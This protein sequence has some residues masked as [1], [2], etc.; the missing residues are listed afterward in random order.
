MNAGMI[1]GTPEG[2]S[3]PPRERPG[4]GGAVDDG[5]R[6]PVFR[7]VVEVMGL[8]A[9]SEWDGAVRVDYLIFEAVACSVAAACSGVA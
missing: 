2:R 1:H 4:E 9:R 6:A 3:T 5:R 8:P 7:E